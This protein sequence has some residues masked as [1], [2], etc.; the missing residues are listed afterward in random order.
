MYASRAK[1]LQAQMQ[2]AGDEVGD[3]ADAMQFLAGLPPAYGMISTVLTAS[4]QT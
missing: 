2:A 3:Q 1:N 4:D